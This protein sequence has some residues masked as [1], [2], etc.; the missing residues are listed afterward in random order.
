MGEVPELDGGE[1]SSRDLGRLQVA[2]IGAVIATSE[3]GVPFTITDAA[4]APIEAVSEFVREFTACDMSHASSRSYAHDLLRWW[5]FLAAVEV[6][7]DQAQRMEVRDLVRWLRCAPNSQRE[8][9]RSDTPAPGSINRRTGKRHLAEGYAPATINHQL[10]VLS[11]FYDFHLA[12]GRGPA[13]NPVPPAGRGFERLNAHHN[14]MQPYAAHRRGNYRQRV[15]E[16][17]PRGI[18]DD[19]FNGLFAAMTCNRDRAILATYVSS[20]A[21]ASELLGM[22]CGDLDFGRKTI[23][24]IGKGTRR[25]E[26]TPASADA[27]TWVALYLGEGHVWPPDE[28]LPAEAPL[29]VTQRG[30]ARPLTYTAMRAVL[31]RANA[32]LGANLTLHDLRH[33]CAV[34]MAGDPNMTL[35][36]VQA[37]LRHKSLASTQIYTKIQL[38]ELVR[39][40]SEHQARRS[41]PPPPR[42][43]PAYAAKDLAVLFGESV[44]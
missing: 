33:T 41:Q 8:R 44:E 14:P 34:R 19:L 11:T 2:R 36:D 35:S 4:G 28:P 15:P 9:S 13:I 32:K 40:I 39:K 37:V 27:F 18:P 12:A 24:L 6:E 38:E 22:R 26:E 42:S 3:P 31:N 23:T 29:W 7:W 16:R 25:R 30:P 43:H 1:W 20:G 5:R 17:L 21:R 10:A